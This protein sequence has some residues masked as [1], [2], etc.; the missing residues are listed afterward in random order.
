MK[1][2]NWFRLSLSNATSDS[3]ERMAIVLGTSDREI[4]NRVCIGAASNIKQ[5]L[6]SIN[7]G[8]IP[9]PVILFFTKI[10]NRMRVDNTINDENSPKYTSY[11]GFDPMDSFMTSWLMLN[12]NQRRLK[13]CKLIYKVISYI[14]ACT[15]RK[16]TELKFVATLIPPVILSPEILRNYYSHHE[17][18]GDKDI[19]RDIIFV[20]GEILS[21]PVRS[22]YEIDEMETLRAKRDIYLSTT[23]IEKLD[24]LGSS[25]SINNSEMNLTTY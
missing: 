11:E 3:E 16:D 20:W 10:Y 18:D 17:K 23:E 25:M 9:V 19:L 14:C 4:T 7:G 8:L 1:S 12:I 22:C 13:I 21:G 2:E 6:R 24:N 15:A 5:A